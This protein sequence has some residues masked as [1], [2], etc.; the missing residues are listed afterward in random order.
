MVGRKDKKYEKID[1]WLD[2]QENILKKMMGCWMDRTIY[3]KK[4]DG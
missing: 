4:M 1:E 2:G 3:E